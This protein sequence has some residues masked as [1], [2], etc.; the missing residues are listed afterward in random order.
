[1]YG[2]TTWPQEKNSGFA[3]LPRPDAVA[4]DGAFAGT[5]GIGQFRLNDRPNAFLWM[6]DK[7]EQAIGDS[8]LV[9]HPLC[10][11]RNHFVGGYFKD[12]NTKNYL[13]PFIWAKGKLTPLPMP[14][15]PSCWGQVTGIN[16]Q[17][18]CVGTCDWQ[19]PIENGVA[20]INHAVLWQDG[21]FF[22]LNTLVPKEANLEIVEAYGINK[23][24]TI[25]A[26]ATPTVTRW[27]NKLILL[28]RK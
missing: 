1:L 11:S 4:P 7:P 12:L 10:I 25:L 20:N 3:V 24:G 15:S 5:K 27:P 23:D 21:K 18:D 17:G 19:E 14:Q 16:E 26:R 28:K 8:K 22:D 6:K 13:Q 9:A 2:V